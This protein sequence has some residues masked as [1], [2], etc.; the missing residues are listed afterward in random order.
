MS[1]IIIL[2]VLPYQFWII[3]EIAGNI[4]PPFSWS[5]VHNSGD[6]NTMIRVP[7]NGVVR[8]D[9]WGEIAFGYI[10]FLLFGTGTDAHNSY[11]RMFTSIGLG[12]VFPNLYIMSE[13]GGGG[14]AATP[15]SMSFI[16]GW[17]SK[18][19]GVF[20][21]KTGDVF[22]E[23]MASTRSMSL[24]PAPAPAHTNESIPPPR[25]LMSTT[26]PLL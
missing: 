22:N 24:G 1:I 8:F 26:T 5:R 18:A 9:R 25:A 12:K 15:S 16:K 23:S 6:W 4:D 17:T 19:K 10:L 14:S 2:F 13:S 21:S 7:T 20:T 3:A 11:K